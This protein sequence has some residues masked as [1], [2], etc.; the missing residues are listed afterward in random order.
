MK[1]KMKFTAVGDILI[2]RRLPGA[3]DGFDEIRAYIC[4]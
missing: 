4:K 2:Q 1:S 3:Y